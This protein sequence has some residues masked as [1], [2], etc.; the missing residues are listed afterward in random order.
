MA[1]IP[2]RSGARVRIELFGV[3]RLKASTDAL[4]VQARDVVQAL[5]ALGARCPTLVPSVVEEGVLSPAY[6]VAINGTRF[7]DDPHTL[8]HD[9]DVI[10]IVSAQA[11]G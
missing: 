8:L 11:G 7:D 2:T 3:P 4:E 1:T 5:R 9:G 6:V 10:V